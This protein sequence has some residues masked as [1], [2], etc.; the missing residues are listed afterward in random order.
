MWPAFKLHGC[1]VLNS[2]QIKDKEL[3][4]F[5]TI[6]LSCWQSQLFRQERGNT[7]LRAKYSS[8]RLRIVKYAHNLDLL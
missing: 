7:L 6:H 5:V 1:A 2:M 3:V 4:S 8:Y